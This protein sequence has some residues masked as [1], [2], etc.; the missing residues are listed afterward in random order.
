M[1]EPPATTA[2]P[3]PTRMPEPFRRQQHCHACPPSPRRART[4]PPRLRLHLA[5][6][7]LRGPG[8]TWNRLPRRL[9]LHPGQH[10]PGPVPT[11]TVL[12]AAM[13]VLD[14]RVK[15]LELNGLPTSWNPFAGKSEENPS[16]TGCPP[17]G[18]RS[19]GRARRRRLHSMSSGP[20]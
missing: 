6:G 10:T 19:P 17:V 5:P 4:L 14:S 1:A 2:P 12:T 9:L 8:R 3:T 16:S 15:H 7:M 18:T 20:I 13:Q 11:L